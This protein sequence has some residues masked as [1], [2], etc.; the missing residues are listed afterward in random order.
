MARDFDTKKWHGNQVPELAFA[1]CVPGME[2]KKT[3][4]SKHQQTKTNKKALT[5]VC[6]LWAKV[7]KRG[8]LTEQN[9][10]IQQLLYSSEKTCS[11]KAP[12]K[13]VGT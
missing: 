8:N 9:T 13:R 5:K 10:S 1:S 4:I 11:V 2:L 7:Q 6:C 3:A 12:I